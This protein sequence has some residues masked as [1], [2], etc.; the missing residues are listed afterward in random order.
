[1]Y[2]KKKEKGFFMK[3]NDK[4]SRKTKASTKV[5]KGKKMED[6][7]QT[8]GKAESFEPNSLD[9]IWG[10]TGETKYGHL[11]EIRYQEELNHMTKSDLFAHASRH[12]VIP[13]DNRDQLEK[14]L[15][16]EFNKYVL[17]FRKPHHQEDSVTMNNASLE[18]RKILEEGK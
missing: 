7:S 10:D 13:I 8:H 11:D 4:S 17:E 16:R 15:A 3:N 6:L 18:A 12:G 1:M 14:R 9:Q 5:S 2:A